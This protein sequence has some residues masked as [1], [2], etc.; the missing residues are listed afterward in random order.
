MAEEE[1]QQ[2]QQ[3]NLSTEQLRWIGG[4]TFVDKFEDI[5]DLDKLINHGE[6]ADV[7]KCRLKNRQTMR[8]VKCIPK[9]GNRKTPLKNASHVTQLDHPNLVVLREIV[10]TPSQIYIVQD[11]IDGP[12]LFQKIGQ[13][14]VY[15]E[16]DISKYCLQILKG[17]E[18][19][20]EHQ[21]YHGKLHGENIVIRNVENE[22][23]LCLVDYAY[24]NLCTRD[25]ITL[26]VNASPSFCAP[27]LLRGDPF[28]ASSDMWQLGIL[29]YFCLTASYPFHG[30]QKKIFQKILN[31]NIEYNSSEWEHISANGK[32]FVSKLLKVN[33][34]ERLTVKQ[35]F[36]HPWIREKVYRAE[37]LSDAQAKIAAAHPIIIQTEPNPADTQTEEDDLDKNED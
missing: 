32:S 12:N 21:V 37:T 18:Y 11:Y 17:L 31:G 4:S 9:R 26:L 14:E 10:E 16:H 20:H 28:S 7:Y 2:Q 33:V 3:E 29:V 22:S 1:Q 34:P 27:E 5:Y 25:A 19:M 36:S 30:T 35:A 15:T 13:T 6:F 8:A 24:S 23:K